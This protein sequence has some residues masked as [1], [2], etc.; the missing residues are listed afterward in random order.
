MFTLKEWLYGAVLGGVVLLVIYVSTERNRTEP[1][2]YHASG[3]AKVLPD[4]DTAL[5]TSLLWSAPALERLTALGESDA[6]ERL[7]LRIAKYQVTERPA[8]AASGRRCAAA[9]KVATPDAV[10][11]ADYDVRYDVAWLK[12]GEQWAVTIAD[13]V[14]TSVPLCGNLNV[15]ASI[16]R[17]LAVDRVGDPFK[18]REIN[19]VAKL[20]AL[21]TLV[22]TAFDPDRQRRTCSVRASLTLLNDQVVYSDRPVGYFIHW[23]NREQGRT[24][25]EIQS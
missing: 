25:I 3:T 13:I 7:R 22:E 6:D 2:T 10:E 1:V 21:D 24:L 9:I 20:I 11:S 18:T 17:A 14:P 5:G 23:A 8:T 4:C 16:R 19:G 12:E 15:L